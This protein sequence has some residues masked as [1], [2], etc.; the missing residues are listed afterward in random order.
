MIKLFASDMDG[1]LLDQNHELNQTNADAIKALQ[2]H[3]IE[4][5]IST[6]RDYQSARNFLANYNIDCAMINLNGAQIYDEK[7]QLLEQCPIN[8]ATTQQ[9]FDYLHEKQLAHS[10]TTRDQYYLSNKQEYLNHMLQAHDEI[11]E[12]T[13]AQVTDKIMVTLD[14]SD[15]QLSDDNP[16]FKMMVISDDA[17]A[18]DKARIYLES[19]S[20]LD[21]TS[22]GPGNLEITHIEAQKGL[23]LAKYLARK[24]YSV[25]EVL[26]IGDSLNDRS[27]LAM[28][29]NSY[30]MDNAS[31]EVKAMAAYLAPSNVDN[32][33]ATI[34]HQLIEKQS[35]DA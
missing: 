5:I 17:Q 16:V 13:L 28:C 33:V 18:L 1:T 4:F 21:I 19:F 8:N 31:D 26:T 27:M 24:H 7:G 30:A 3:G 9:V 29:P 22:S 2:A 32:G 23:A 6:G 34:I 12:V 11:D 35:E 20:D 25:E 15:Y 10:L 14:A